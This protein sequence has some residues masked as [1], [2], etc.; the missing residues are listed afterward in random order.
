MKNVLKKLEVGLIVLSMMLSLASCGEKV[1]NGKPGEE[2][3]TLRYLMTGPGKQQDSEVVWKEFNK[4]LQ[5]QI[6]NLKIE[7]EVFP[8][9]DY[10]Q[11]FMLMQTSREKMDIANTYG[12]NFSDEV[13][14]GTF[15][16]LDELIAKYG[17][18]VKKSLPEWLWDYSNV[19]GKIY[20]IP[21]YQMMCVPQGL[22]F[23]KDDMEKY[24]DL[25]AITK[26]LHENENFTAEY[27]DIME[28][29]LK[30]LKDNG[31][32]GLGYQTGMYITKGFEQ[33][34]DYFTIRVNDETCKVEYFFA[35][36]EAKMYFDKMADWYK[37]GYIRADSLSVK[38]NDKVVGKKEGYSVWT[39]QLGFLQEQLDKE[40]YNEDIINVPFEKEFYIPASN[41]AGGTAIMANTEHPEMAM[42]F[43]N[44]MQ[45]EKGKDLYNMLVYGIEGDHYKKISDDVI[46]TEYHGQATSNDRYGLYKWIV[47]NTSLA[48]DT[49][50][51]LK[52]YKEWVFEDVNKSEK[53]SRLIGFVV[54]TDNIAAKLAQIATVKDEFRAS[55]ASGSIQNHEETYNQFMTKLDKAGVKDVIADLQKQVDEFLLK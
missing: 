10:K 8:M 24:G 51:D 6:P 13:K 7:F 49:Q 53:R 30:N 2:M 29:Y 25:N 4:K 41:A 20:S 31:R 1:T 50:T 43:L 42:K 16:E 33:I 45:S 38:D 46:E 5:E 15:L 23:F 44:L 36:D 28:S 17:S 40:K 39:A 9:A 14:K 35:T 55:L 54:N 18:D 48:Y 22:K 47:G 32:I 37:K 27:Y 12:L 52:G 21:S 11:Q 3:V 34:V 26:V 19:G